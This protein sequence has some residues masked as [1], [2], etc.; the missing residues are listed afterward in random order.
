MCSRE[1]CGDSSV[2]N[3]SYNEHLFIITFLAILETAKL[4]LNAG[5]Y[6]ITFFLYYS[7]TLFLFTIIFLADLIN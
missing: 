7:Q 4:W 6:Y 5:I 3:L 2:R 1:K